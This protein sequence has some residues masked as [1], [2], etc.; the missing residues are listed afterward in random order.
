[1]AI[2]TTTTTTME[3]ATRTTAGIGRTRALG[4]L[5][6]TAAAAAVWALAVPLLGIQLMVRFGGAAP[7]PVG[8]AYVVA[9]SLVGS[10]LGWGLLTVLERRTARARGIWTGMALVVG[11][12]SL[13]LPLTAATTMS[14]RISLT[15]MHVAVA[16]VLIAVLRR[17]PAPPQLGS[18]GSDR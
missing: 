5:G 17:M 6:A 10:L 18:R 8:I 14:T 9:A 1:M 13:S 2:I 4:V 15:L 7:Q 3:T 12:G 16:G 11:L